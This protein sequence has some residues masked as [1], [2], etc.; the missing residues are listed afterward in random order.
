MRIEEIYLFPVKS[1]RG[2]KV[3]EA[4]V[5]KHGLQYDRIYML[6]LPTADPKTVRF[7][8][9]RE[10]PKLVKVSQRIEGDWIILH[11]DETGKELKL[12]ADPSDR[13]KD[14]NVVNVDVWGGN[15]ESYDIGSTIQ[16]FSEFWAGLLGPKYDGLTILARKTSRPLDPTRFKPEDLST[17]DYTPET[18]FQ[19]GSPANLICTASLETL[20]LRVNV[21]TEGIELSAENFRPNLVVATEDP[22][23]EDDWDKIKI[24]EDLWIITDLCR[25]CQMPTVNVENGEFEKSKQPTRALNQFRKVHYKHPSDPCFGM[26]LYPSKCGQSVRVGDVVEVVSKVDRPMPGDV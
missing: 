17:M 20:Q 21:Q 25:R 6:A 24:G 16:G 18:T 14:L 5:L 19:D 13:F 11:N 15:V 22:F 12:P 10:E 9:Q 2:I 7:V 3:K 8:T 23:E 1:L 4:K 26:E